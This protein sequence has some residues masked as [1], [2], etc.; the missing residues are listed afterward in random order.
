MRPRH[1]NDL[2]DHLS[3]YLPIFPADVGPKQ[4]L[5]DAEREVKADLEDRQ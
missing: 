5:A 3:N 2:L 4:R 1:R